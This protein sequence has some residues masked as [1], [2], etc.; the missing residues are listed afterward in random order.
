MLLHDNVERL[1]ASNALIVDTCLYAMCHANRTERHDG[2]D[3]SQV[4]AVPPR[5]AIW[6]SHAVTAQ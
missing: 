3:F 4:L 2:T 5:L 6:R 1:P